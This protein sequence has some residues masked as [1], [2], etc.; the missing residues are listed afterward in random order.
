M[1]KNILIIVFVCYTL[2]K[3]NRNSTEWEDPKG[4]SILIILDNPEFES[5]LNNSRNIFYSCIVCSY[6][7]FLANGTDSQLNNIIESYTTPD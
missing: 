7:F 2:G 4:K 5:N 3:R 1:L 6:S